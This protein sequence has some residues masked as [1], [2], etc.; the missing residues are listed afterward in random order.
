MTRENWQDMQFADAKGHPS[1]F[2]QEC[3]ELRQDNERLRRAMRA[4]HTFC[5]AGSAPTAAKILQ[6]ALSGPQTGVG[7]PGRCEQG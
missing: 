6:D 3:R 5:N 7:D 1:T 4:A 2:E